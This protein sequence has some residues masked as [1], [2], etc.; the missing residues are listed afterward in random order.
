MNAIT[1]VY[2]KFKSRAEVLIH[3]SAK[4]SGERINI[5]GTSLGDSVAC[6]VNGEPPNQD[7]LSPSCG[8]SRVLQRYQ[9]ENHQKKM[10]N[11]TILEIYSTK[12]CH[13]SVS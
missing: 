2:K 10:H 7:L 11:C 1:C 5:L 9:L 4:G 8:S 13:T 6:C 12:P 3:F